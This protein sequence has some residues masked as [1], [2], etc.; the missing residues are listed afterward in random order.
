MYYSD[1]PISKINNDL[2]V[3]SNFSKKLAQLIKNYKSDDGLVIGLYGK[4]GS[5]K[6]SV[7]NMAIE[8]IERLES[9]FENKTTILKFNP[10]NFSDNNDLIL[11]FFEFLK[12]KLKIN[13]NLKIRNEI[14]NA[15]I[16]YSDA[17]EALSVI[18]TIGS[19]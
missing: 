5:G 14:G 12:N 1:K 19:V 9:D 4:W 3:R 13:K 15:L 6:T 11:L 8:E 18:P 16:K 7:I 17:F 2:L 10:W